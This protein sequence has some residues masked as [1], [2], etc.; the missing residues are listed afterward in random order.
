[1]ANEPSTEPRE[2][3][4]H[5]DSSCPTNCILHPLPLPRQQDMATATTTGKE[6]QQHTVV[7]WVMKSFYIFSVFFLHL[8][9]KYAGGGGA[10]NFIKNF[11]S[12][13]G[14]SC[15]MSALYQKLSLEVEDDKNRL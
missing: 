2:N 14:E 1:M 11:S 10:I 12:C 15:L 7:R 3:N 8:S 6:R 4:H 9:L 5:R 13:F